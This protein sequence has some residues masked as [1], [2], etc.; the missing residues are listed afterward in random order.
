MTRDEIIEIFDQA[1][2]SL[3]EDEIEGY[4]EDFKS[5]LAFTDVLDE[6]DLQGVEG[7]EHL[8]DKNLS[9]RDDVESQSLERSEALENSNFATDRYFKINGVID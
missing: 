9:L 7:L 2:L 4:Q 3:E 5:L 1:R 6:L 8:V